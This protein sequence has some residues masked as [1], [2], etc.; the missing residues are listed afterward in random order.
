MKKHYKIKHYDSI[1]T[2]K[3]QRA[4]IILRYF[5]MLCGLSLF[6]YVG[7]SLFPLI[8]KDNFEESS[9]TSSWVNETT[10]TNVQSAKD[11][12]VQIQPA[13][14]TNIDKHIKGLY[15]PPADQANISFE[16]FLSA[17]KNNDISAVVIDAKDA[18]G[19][20]LYRS[21]NN[22]VKRIGA[23]TDTAFD[24]QEVTAKILQ[25]G[26]TPIARIHAFRDNVAPQSDRN[27]AVKYRDTDVLWLDNSADQG[28]RAWLNPYS[29]EAQ[30]YIIDVT[31]ELIGFGF[32]QVIIDS[33][34]FPTGYALDLAGYGATD[35]LSRSEVLSNFMRRLESAATEA[36]GEAMLYVNAVCLSNF[37]VNT[38]FEVN[39]FEPAGNRIVLGITP[40]TM[41]NGISILNRKFENPY[42]ERID[43]IKTAISAVKSRKENSEI[44][45]LI[46]LINEDGT[47]MPHSEMDSVIDSA[48]RSGVKG[49]ILYDPQGSYPVKQ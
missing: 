48:I 34:G 17:A 36:G 45:M 18:T 28:G 47:T 44:F 10:E 41:I 49:T 32:Q 40:S 33:V 43:L 7:W 25:A 37:A 35:G 31:L 21:E 24:A 46:M 39:G 13:E 42:T 15:Y 29:E 23:V 5:T 11:K 6:A 4:L 22:T 1:Y 12:Q 26:L 20:I 9:A 30:N 27:M 14:S 19:E 16:Q 3:K 38:P 8:I 2:T